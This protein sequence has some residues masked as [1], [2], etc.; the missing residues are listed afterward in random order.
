[1][2][3]MD[4]PQGSVPWLDQPVLLHSSRADKCKLTPAQCA[5]RGNHWRYWYGLLCERDGGLIY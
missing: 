3:D 1:M 4:M 2:K 5:F